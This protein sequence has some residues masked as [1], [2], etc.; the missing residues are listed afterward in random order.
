MAERFARLGVGTVGDLA[1]FL[2]S[3]IED[4]SRVMAIA[5]LRPEE[6][7]VITG[8]VKSVS[9]R[10][11]Q[12]GSL[13]VQAIIEDASGKL[14]AL[15]FNQRYVIRF[16]QP[17]QTVVLYGQK[18]L[19]K[20]LNN[21]FFVEKIIDQAGIWPVYPATAGL[22][23][24]AI[25]KAISQIR[26]VVES[27]PDVLPSSIRELLHLPSRSEALV[28]CH[29]NPTEAALLSVRRLLDAE[30][31]YQL[32]T[33]IISAKKELSRQTIEATVIELEQIKQFIGQ[34][35]FTLTDSQR[36]A[37]WEIIQALGQEQPMNR[38][39]Y[40]EVGSGKTAVAV[41]A[42][43]AVIRSGRRVVLLAPTLALVSQLAAVTRELLAS[44]GVTIAVRT[45]VVKEDLAAANLIIGTHALLE[46]SAAMSNVGLV[47]IDEQHRF[48]VEERNHL[49]TQHPNTHL[50]MMTATPIPRSLAQ[51]IFSHLELTTISGKPAHQQA[52][53]TVIFSDDRRTD[54][55]REI[56]VRLNRGEPGYVICP[57]IDAADHGASDA[58]DTLL[59]SERRAVTKELARLKKVFPN[60][61]I[62]MLHG[63]LKGT[64]K[65]QIITDW[66]AGVYDILLSTTVVEV[67]IDNPQAS[68][69]L[70]EE[71]DRF[72]LSQLH[73]L[74][75]RVGRGQAQSVCFLADSAQSS[76]GRE[77]LAV[78]KA[79]ND[80]L[81]L[82]EEDLRLR[83]PG[84]LLGVAQSGLPLL[85]AMQWS[86]TAAIQQIFT[87]AQDLLD[88]TR[89]NG[90]KSLG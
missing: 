50:L 40:G 64:E 37:A 35:L 7:V 49:L 81:K 73:Q 67:G 61:Q 32:A 20:A 63:R 45:G 86:D 72:G 33:G 24:A 70:I 38:L 31:L 22:T 6:K 34:L 79:T 43:L 60:R 39:L 23:Q 25:R 46:Q 87:A 89:S 9:S 66:R 68:W 58:A 48:G 29:F 76:L 80:G 14:P 36:R 28:A 10:R 21:P 84:E 62:A 8:V 69:V 88:D 44:E 74:R 56:A 57:L 83:G 19:M 3:R 30:D 42:A 17:G 13:I 78:I 54:I 51:T 75:G 82:A 47:I 26:P 4:C 1:F 90:S 59:N 85:R 27:V 18:K 11:S 52:V 41:I 5:G 53:E 15:W 77:R 55:E 16:L 2:P 12:K 65:E 71:A